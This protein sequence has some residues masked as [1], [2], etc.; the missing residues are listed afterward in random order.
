MGVFD[1]VTIRT[2]PTT[3]SCQSTCVAMLLRVTPNKVIQQFHKDYAEHDAKTTE[4]LASKG[5]KS[6]FCGEREGLCNYGAYI[7]TVPSLNIPKALHSVVVIG[8]ET[9]WQLLDPN[10]H[11]E[12]VKHYDFEK[13]EDDPDSEG[14]GT[15]VP[16]IFVP[17]A[18]IVRF[19]TNRIM[20][21]CL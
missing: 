6:F 10:F 17:E 2:Q 5:L 3:T 19:H 8:N 18:E 9:H 4:Y 20:R 16:E 13:N 7:C 1:F 14:L 15:M 21:V 11:R 12:G